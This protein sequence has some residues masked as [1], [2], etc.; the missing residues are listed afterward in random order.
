MEP[1][2]S[3][4]R[5]AEKRKK[6][7][8]KKK[9][10]ARSNFPTQQKARETVVDFLLALDSFLEIPIPHPFTIDLSIFLSSTTSLFLLFLSG[11][12]FLS[13]PLLVW[14]SCQVGSGFV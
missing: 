9:K 10:H 3:E 8:E 7:N 5:K 4:A 13:P 6:K 2:L 12:G 11:R 1:D 14:W